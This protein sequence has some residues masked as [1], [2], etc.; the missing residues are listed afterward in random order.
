MSIQPIYLE[1][2][3]VILG[4]FLIMLE[5]FSAE[6]HNRTIIAVCGIVG[7]TAVFVATFFCAANGGPAASHTA[8]YWKFYSADSFA[9]FFKRFALLCTILTLVMAIEFK[10]LISRFIFG[11]SK[12]AGVG[13]FF[14]LPVLTCAGLMWMASAVDFVM[15]FV[16]L[17]LVSISFYVLVA[18]MRR[19]NGS[20]EAGVKYLI[21]S[22]L[23]A[24][25]LVYGIAW[26]FGLTN[27]TNLND[28]SVYLAN[29]HV[30]TVPLMFAIFLILVAFGF[31]IAATPFQFWIPDVYQGAP[32]PI[33]A[34]LSVASKAAGFVVL[35]RILYTFL[36]IP[37]LHEKLTLLITIFAILSLIYGN[38][39]AMP[40]MNFKRLLAYSSI[41]HAG[42]L[43]MA[44][45]C[46]AATSTIGGIAPH[47][48]KLSPETFPILFTRPDTIQAIN[49]YLIAYLLMTMLAFFIMLIVA[50]HH[51]GDNRAGD[52]IADFNGLAKR[53]PFLAFGMLISVCSLAGIPFTIGFFGKFFIFEVAL[54]AHQYLLV[55]IGVI[56]VAAGFYYYLKIVRAMYWEAP[57]DNAAPIRY[58]A[59]S[60]IV[61]ALIVIAIIVFG[62]FPQPIYD[63]FNG[64]Q[65]D[66]LFGQTG[67]HSLFR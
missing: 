21:L 67:V 62:I 51:R 42:Y 56:A 28:I 61:I 50:N 3:V 6:K 53:S 33:A 18:Y 16:S 29:H 4:I 20:L 13:E 41:A 43:L 23:S 26:I 54:A 47:M 32:T 52:D 48:P 25:F 39:S 9:M 34:Y 37:A 35:I 30:P 64:F 2:A 7:L 19:N 40:Q 46:F 44:L 55:V 22:A 15:I 36:Q 49:F 45:A 24:G 1:T 31:K 66:S 59:F 57:D 38:L 5:A 10:G 12:E 27:H 58:S 63:F 11:A 65:P 8:P 60:K 14:V 17:E